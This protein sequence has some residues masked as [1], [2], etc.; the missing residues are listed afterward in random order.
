MPY[1]DIKVRQRAEFIS[2]GVGGQTFQLTLGSPTVAGNTLLLV[3]NSIR[4][5]LYT[6]VDLLSV[7][8]TVNGSGGNTWGSITNYDAD[9]GNGGTTLWGVMAQNI[10]AGTTVV[11][12]TLDLAMTQNLVGARLLEI[13]GV[14]T[15]GVEAFTP[16]TARSNNALQNYIDS[17]SSGTLPQTDVLL[18]GISGGPYGNPSNEGTWTEEMSVSNGGG[19]IGFQVATRKVTATDAVTFRTL[20]DA[21]IANY[22]GSILFGLKAKAASTRQ[23]Q[24]QFD[25][26]K[27]NNTHG[28]FTAFVLVNGDCDQVLAK[29]FTNV[30]ATAGGLVVCT[31][32]DSG[33]QLS[34]TIKIQ[35]EGPTITSGWATGSCVD[36]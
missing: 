22:R 10:A 35:I 1:A 17:A 33:A 30:T 21:D 7:S 36:A 25:P 27:L 19:K 28:A 32:A 4:A 20:H 12:G 13:E 8:S 31:P 34:D 6:G 5:D 26:L 24:A 11:A 29:R 23:Y 15:S 3:G 16:V 2:S 14:P 18:V 9:P